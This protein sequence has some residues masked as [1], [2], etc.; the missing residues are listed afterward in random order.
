MPFVGPESG[1]PP[2]ATLSDVECRLG[3]EVTGSEADRLGCLL[4]DAS[5]GV[6]S[7]TGQEFTASSSTT[8]LKVRGG[9]VRLPQWPV[10]AVTAVASTA[11][12]ALMHTWTSGD[13]V[14]LSSSLPIA[15]G[16]SCSGRGPDYVDVTY[17]HG[18]DASPPDVV[19][20]VAQ[21]AGRALGT[22]PGEG[23]VQSETIAGYSYTLG[24]AAAAG[25]LGMLP[26]ERAVLD[27]Y[28]VPS[29]PINMA[30]GIR[31]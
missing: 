12:T 2:L 4:V 9:C 10:T 31:R 19:A 18:F 17:E 11:G 13:R 25:G 7:Y 24:S 8:R 30:G 15:N 28:K 21:M 22:T 26:A 16:P 27:R 23:G 5:A 6:R 3:R 1:L 29:G 14:W 20:V